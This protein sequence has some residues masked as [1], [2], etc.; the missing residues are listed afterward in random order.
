MAINVTIGDQANQLTSEAPSKPPQATIEL[1]LRKTLEGDIVIF[2]HRDIDIVLMPRKNK[3]I[4]FGKENYGEEVYAAINRLFNFLSRKG[5]I[6]LGSERGGHIYSSVE[7]TI[8]DNDKHSSMQI[9]LFTIS[10]WIEEERPYL[11]W[12]KK[13]EDDWEHSLTAPSGEESTEFD[14]NRHKETKGSVNPHLRPYGM[15]TSYVYE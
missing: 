1:Q 8:P 5:V 12:E 6:E 9:V 14:P 15:Y 13:I 2:D 10:N 3:V 4:A 11:E 7:A